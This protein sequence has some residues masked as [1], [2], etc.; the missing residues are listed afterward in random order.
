MHWITCQLG[1]REHYS[2]PRALYASN[3]LAG[4]FTDAWVR[5]ENILGILRHRVRDRFHPDLIKASVGSANLNLMC[6]EAVSRTLRRSG[7][8]AIIRRNEWF[9][10]QAVRWLE[11]FLRVHRNHQAAEPPVLFAYS[12]AARD[13]FVWARA[14]GWRTV[15]GQIDPGPEEERLMVSLHH[16]FGSAVPAWNSAPESYWTA[17]REEC[18][19]ADS[20]IVNSEWSRELLVKTGISEAKIAQV[21]LAYTPSQQALQFCR[22]IPQTFTADRPLRVLFL[23]QVTP[24]KGVVELLEA[25]RQLVSEPVEFLIVGPVLFDIATELKSLPNVKLIGSVPRSQVDLWY[26]KADIFIFPTHSDGFGLTQLEAQGWKLPIVAS[27]HCGAVVKDGV[28]G[29]LLKEVSAT[30]ITSAM[31]RLCAE[32]GLAASLSAGQSTIPGRPLSE[33]AEQLAVVER[34]L[35]AGSG[36]NGVK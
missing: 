34:R 26:Q 5:P 12:Y 18:S 8:D 21:S 36:Q 11:R 17:W 25:A 24:R 23:G 7:W 14:R 30:E 19:L 33:L 28:S 16:Q 32:S 2:I 4:M 29:L 31:T 6:F 1:A 3:R 20:I 10:R 27:R 13:L 22:R 35:Q 15:L 9:Q